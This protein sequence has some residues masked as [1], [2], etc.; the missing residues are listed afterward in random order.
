M[1]IYA[2]PLSPS[3]TSEHTPPETLVVPTPDGGKEHTEASFAPASTWLA[4]Q[5][6]GQITLF[7]P[8]AYLLTLLAQHLAGGGTYQEQRDRLMVFVRSCPAA[9]PGEAGERA[10]HAHFTAGIRWA[11]KVMCPRNLFV[12]DG[13]GRLVLGLERPGP[14]LE[15]TGRG[16]DWE[17]VVL[18]RFEK[19]GPREVEVMRRED[20][21]EEER[22][23]NKKESNL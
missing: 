8:Q 14:E 3:A 6:A 2:L 21:F 23:A 4:R 16:G 10:A 1:Y 20:A 11:D 7:P 15:G 13:D 18:A 19:G 5:A 9:E 17:R 12:R 22:R